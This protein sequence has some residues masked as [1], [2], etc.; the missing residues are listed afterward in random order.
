M[1]YQPRS[2]IWVS[3]KIFPTSRLDGGFP[4]G[5]LPISKEVNRKKKSEA[6]GASL[7]PV[8][9]Y[10]HHFTKIKHFCSF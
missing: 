8:N 3:Q 7:V 4:K 9:G 1:V 6:E 2:M 10:G 5:S